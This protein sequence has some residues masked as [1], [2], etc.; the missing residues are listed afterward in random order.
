MSDEESKTVVVA[1]TP[2]EKEARRAEADKERAIASIPIEQGGGVQYTN[3]M[4]DSPEAETAKVLLQYMM[5]H[6]REVEFECLGD[7][8]ISLTG[9]LELILVCPRC[10]SQGVP[11]GRAQLKIAQSNKNWELDVRKAGEPILFDG[12]FYRSAGRVRECPLSRCPDCNWSFKIDDN[13]LYP[14]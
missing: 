12:A 9:E 1:E 13:K 8:T 5:P 4:T 7:V 3:R 14:Q 11:H 10:I 2:A 6:G